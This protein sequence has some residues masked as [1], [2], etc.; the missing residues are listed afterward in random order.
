MLDRRIVDYK[1][2]LDIEISYVLSRYYNLNINNDNH[3]INSRSSTLAIIYSVVHE[4][5]EYQEL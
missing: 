2:N 4:D 1:C 5:Q 3:Q